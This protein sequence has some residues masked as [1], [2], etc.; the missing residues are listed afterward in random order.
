VKSPEIAATL[1]QHR[2]ENLSANSA[3]GGIGGGLVRDDRQLEEAGR[4]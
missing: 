2:L 4:D 1:V 3:V